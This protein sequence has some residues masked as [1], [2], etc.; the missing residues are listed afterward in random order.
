MS[1]SETASTGRIW[2]L[3]IAA[4]AALGAGILLLLGG[5]DDDSAQAERPMSNNEPVA[6]PTTPHP[7]PSSESSQ[8]A[9]ESV[10]PRNSAEPTLTE[11]PDSEER[12]K[13]EKIEQEAVEEAVAGLSDSQRM[14]AEK[15][16]MEF[17]S[18]AYARSWDLDRSEWTAELETV[19]AADVIAELN[20]DQDWDSYD[21]EAFV[22]GHSSTKVRIKTAE[23]QNEQDEQVEVAVSFITST[24]SQDPWLE[25]PDRDS[26]E[27][28]VVDLK[29]DKVVD[30]HS[31]EIAGGL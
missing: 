20:K 5:G 4:L 1:V 9:S 31:M 3:M 8:P 12:L 24:R 17:V 13:Q 29:Q 6:A 27:T 10:S 14:A 15:T 2:P 18:T 21:R 26:A 16:A 11:A 19:A 25:A 22:E 30:R 23:A 28:V 7:S